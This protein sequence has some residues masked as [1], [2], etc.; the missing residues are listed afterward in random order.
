MPSAALICD[1][2]PD[3][4]RDNQASAL[5]NLASHELRTPLNSILGFSEIL[6]DELHGPLGSPQYQDYAKIIRGGGEQLLGMVN[7]LLEM[8]RLEARMRT[9]LPRRL[10][11]RAAAADALTALDDQMTRRNLT[12][13][14][15][16]GPGAETVV[17]D[18]ATLRTVL[19]NLLQ[20]ACDHA[21]EACEI[22][23]RTVAMGD[24]VE[25]LIEDAGAVHAVERRAGLG[26]TLGV[27]QAL[28]QAMGGALA[29]EDRLTAGVCARVSLPKG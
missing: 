5:V 12:V 24:R 10:S 1:D 2:L 20:Q 4:P 26:L 21:S 16:C 8:A 9:P 28:T 19:A 29:L 17:A 3:P 15:S 13:R 18:A 6:A 14:L 7:Q 27:C 22:A 11:V 23:V 25:I